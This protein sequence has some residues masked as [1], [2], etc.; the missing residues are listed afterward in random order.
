VWILCDYVPCPM[1]VFGCLM[2]PTMQKRLLVESFWE[3][4]Y[5]EFLLETFFA[6]L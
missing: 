3:E 1:A 6:W 2:N 5:S 4:V